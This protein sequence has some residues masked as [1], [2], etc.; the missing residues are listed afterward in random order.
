MNYQIKLKRN[1]GIPENELLDDLKLVSQKLERKSFSMDDYDKNGQ[2]RRGVFK[3]NFGSWNKALDRAGLGILKRGN[4][5][6]TDEDLF[7][8]LATVWEQVGGQPSQSNLDSNI[9]RFHSGIYKKRF[10]TYNKT[11]PL[12]A[13]WAENGDVSINARNKNEPATQGHKTKR[14]INDRL[15]WIVI[16]RDSFKCQHCGWSPAKDFGDRKLE[17][18]H[19]IPWTKGGETILENLQ[20]LCSKCNGGKSNLEI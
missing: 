5:T 10:G 19:K 18:D 6:I 20:T 13:K 3:K 12:F 16:K 14:A 2:F 17:I 7:V 1:G 8:N 4:N 9:S 15:R 11:L